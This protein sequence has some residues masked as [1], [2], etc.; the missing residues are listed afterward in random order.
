[1]ASFNKIII[2]GYLGRD[3]ES[4]F[5]SGGDAVCTFPVATTEK[6]KSNDDDAQEHTTWFRVTCWRRTA[7]VAQEYL[8]KGKQVYVEGK[9]RQN[10]F[11]DR[12]GNKKV[13]LEVTASEIQFLG[14]RG[15]GGNERSAAVDG[16]GDPQTSQSKRAGAA[17]ALG[18]SK[19]ASFGKKGE[20]L[21]IEDD[22]IPF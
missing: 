10:E 4:K 16:K 22:E 3:P 20:A 13:T 21:P 6:R 18:S 8:S 2:V 19:G 14:S 17:K 1:M 7:E 9:L 5:T 15:E 12:E 11:T